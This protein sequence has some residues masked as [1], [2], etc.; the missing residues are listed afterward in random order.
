MKTLLF[1]IL[2]FGG[3][4]FKSIGQTKDSTKV[5]DKFAKYFRYDTDEYTSTKNENWAKNSRTKTFENQGDMHSTYI[6]LNSDSSF[7]FLSIY[8]PGE[9]LSIGTWTEE[10]D[11]IVIL[12]WNK[13]KSKAI[14]NNKKVYKRY[15]QYGM[16]FPMKIENWA[17]VIS[18]DKLIPVAKR[19]RD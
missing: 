19:I 1:I 2:I 13:E 12:T 16:P 15:Y 8:E 5:Y 9:F 7:V 17:F 11:T 3:S 10:N 4:T 6:A 18:K 14:C